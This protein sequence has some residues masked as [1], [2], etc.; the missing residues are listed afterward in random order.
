MRQAITGFHLDEEGHFVA[1]LACG[2]HQHVRHDPPWMNRSWVTTDSG[3]RS[4]LGHPLECV[5]CE[6]DSPAD[7]ARLSI[8][9]TQ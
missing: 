9:E 2:H 3:R 8:T 6:D 4:M 5:K 1:Q 7:P